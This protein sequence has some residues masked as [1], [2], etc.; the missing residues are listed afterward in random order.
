MQ[1]GTRTVAGAVA[2]IRTQTGSS[3][4]NGLSSEDKYFSEYMLSRFR[5]DRFGVSS[6]IYASPALHYDT[7]VNLV[8]QRLA[9]CPIEA[10]LKN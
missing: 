10:G 4:K 2:G 9:F 8:K 6:L 7:D 1:G 3:P 5:W